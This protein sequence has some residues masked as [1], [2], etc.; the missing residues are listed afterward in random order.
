MEFKQ[1]VLNLIPS[2]ELISELKR[3]RDVLFCDVVTKGDVKESFDRLAKE[4]EGDARGYIADAYH[5]ILDDITDD[6][7]LAL[8]SKGISIDE[9][10]KGCSEWQK[11]SK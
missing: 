11:V 4:I 6:I 5:N 10:V 7:S 2:D 9:L 1:S 3:R 8:Q